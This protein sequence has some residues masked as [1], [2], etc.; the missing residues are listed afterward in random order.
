MRGL[1]LI[2]L[3]APIALFAA[4]P[5][6]TTPPLPDGTAKA[7][8]HMAGFRVPQGMK[9]E[10]FA[11]EPMLSSPVAIS[12][13]DKGRVYVAEEYRLGTGAGENRGRAA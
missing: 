7:R 13:D 12:V 1:A 11:A 5:V 2:L 3:A 8:Q 9:V 6:K 4:D 10:L